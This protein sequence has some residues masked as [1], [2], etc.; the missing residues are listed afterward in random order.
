[1]SKPSDAENLSTLLETLATGTP[2]AT[3]YAIQHLIRIGPAAEVPLVA[4]LNETRDAYRQLNMLRVL[5]AIK[6]SQPASV[7]AVIRLLSHKETQVR[8]AAAACLLHSSPKLRPHLSQI[9]A[10][11]ARESD[12]GTRAS[13]QKVLDRYPRH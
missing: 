3:Y 11:A 10:V 8:A 1:M 6:L 12:P 2:R 7:V 5:E 9:Q 13:L 4:L